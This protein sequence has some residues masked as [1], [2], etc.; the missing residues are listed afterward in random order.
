M[1]SGPDPVREGTARE[2]WSAV[3][4]WSDDPASAFDVGESD[5]DSIPLR[6]GPARDRTWDQQIMSP[7]L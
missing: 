6:C 7:P 4:D 1:R 2:K 3:E 5:G